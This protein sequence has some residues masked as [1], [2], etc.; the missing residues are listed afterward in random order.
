MQWELRGEN[1]TKKKEDRRM[2]CTECF[3]ILIPNKKN[4]V[5]FGEDY[6]E[7]FCHAPPCGDGLNEDESVLISINFPKEGIIDY[8]KDRVKFCKELSDDGWGEVDF[9]MKKIFKIKY[10][11]DWYHFLAAWGFPKYKNMYKRKAIQKWKKEFK[12]KDD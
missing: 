12:I 11:V 8:A 5:M 3:E 9:I 10:V 4:C 1:M 7:T 2:V 6:P